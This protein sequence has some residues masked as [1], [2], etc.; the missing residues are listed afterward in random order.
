MSED[1]FRGGPFWTTLGDSVKTTRLVK[2][3]F[4][5]CLSVR[6]TERSKEVGWGGGKEGGGWV[7]FL[8]K[9]ESLLQH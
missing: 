2:C 9:P 8:D 7:P 4:P 1:D 5:I 6:V 3:G